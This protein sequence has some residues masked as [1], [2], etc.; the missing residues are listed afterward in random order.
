MNFLLYVCIFYLLLDIYCCVLT[1]QYAIPAQGV[2]HSKQNK[3]HEQC[4]IMGV[5]VVLIFKQ[6]P[7]Q[8][9]GNLSDLSQAELN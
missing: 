5:V 2:S 8:I 7:L 1:A 6:P 4:R 3:R 9:K